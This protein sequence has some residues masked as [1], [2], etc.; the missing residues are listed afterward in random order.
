MGGVGVPSTGE[1]TDDILPM[2]PEGDEV[3]DAQAQ[4]RWLSIIVYVGQTQLRIMT[5]SI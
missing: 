1:E 2:N 4:H 3:D 5:P